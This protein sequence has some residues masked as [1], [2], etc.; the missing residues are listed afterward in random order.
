MAEFRNNPGAHE[1]DEALPQ[2]GFERR[3]AVSAPS[4][5]DRF[6]KKVRGMVTGGLIAISPVL[7]SCIATPDTQ[8]ETAG[9]G[10]GNVAESKDTLQDRTVNL[11]YDGKDWHF[12][13]KYPK[14]FRL[15][16]EADGKQVYDKE[17]LNVDGNFDVSGVAGEATHDITIKAFDPDAKEIQTLQIP[18]EPKKDTKGMFGVPTFHNPEYPKM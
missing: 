1:H 13:G 15:V 2:R 3:E 10:G 11:W 5:M 18:I 9:Q 12:E 7:G 8:A 16:V 6:L 4:R 14:D 17:V